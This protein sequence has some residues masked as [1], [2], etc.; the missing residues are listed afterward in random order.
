MIKILRGTRFKKEPILFWVTPDNEI[1]NHYSSTTVYYKV[2]QCCGLKQM[3]SMS[4]LQINVQYLG[5]I[6]HLSKGEVWP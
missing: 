2:K 3:F 1:I 4:I 6:I 5:E